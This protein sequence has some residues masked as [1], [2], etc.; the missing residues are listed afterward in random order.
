MEIL[1]FNTSKGKILQVDLT[2]PNP[3]ISYFYHLEEYQSTGW[4]LS[5]KL[6]FCETLLRDNI[7][8]LNL[9]DVDDQ[10]NTALIFAS[11]NINLIPTSTFK[12]LIDNGADVNLCDNDG[13]TA[14]SLLLSDNCGKLCQNVE[15]IK[16]LMVH[17]TNLNTVIG[18]TTPLIYSVQN[19]SIDIE[20]IELLLKVYTVNPN[21]NVKDQYP[22]LS[23]SKE[24]DSEVCEVFK[25]LL[26]YGADINIKDSHGTTVLMSAVSSNSLTIVQYLLSQN[27]NLEDTDDK[28]DTALLKASD[29]GYQAKI[30]EC[31]INKGANINHYNNS[32]KTLISK[33]SENI[34]WYSNDGKLDKFFRIIDLLIKKGWDINGKDGLILL[35]KISAETRDGDYD[36][37]ISML[38]G[39]ITRGARFVDLNSQQLIKLYELSRNENKILQA[40][41]VDLCN[42]K[43]LSLSGILKK[44]ISEYL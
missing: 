8:T 31:L 14:L 5:H 32:G 10:G 9:N 21:L 41:N 28:G 4:K 25:L 24:S 36:I 44:N 11:T 19:P 43:S 16:L 27:V 37:G 18:Y 33:F 30:I 40:Q 13:Y 15:V 1:H 12:L 6:V 2:P 39:L 20:I 29:I 7:T 38:H 26:Q 23:I 22:I 35:R 34:F 42:F 17:S 3:E